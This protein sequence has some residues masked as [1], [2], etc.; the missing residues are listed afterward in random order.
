[1]KPEPITEASFQW[2]EGPI[3]ANDALYFVDIEGQRVLRL[4]PKTEELQDW[5]VGERVGCVVPRASGGLVIAGDFGF[6]FLDTD[7]GRKTPIADPEPEKKPDNRFND[8]KC[9]PAGRFWAGTI[10][11]VKK[12]GD[13]ALYVLDTDLSVSEKLPSLTNSNGI[14]W[15][16]DETLM[17]HIDTPTK[18]ICVYDYDKTTGAISNGRVAVDTSGIEGS[19]DGMAIDDQGGLWVAFCRGGT[20][21][22]LDPDSGAST[23]RIDFPMSG[24]TAC[25][26]GGP[27]LKTLYVTTGKFPNQE[28]PMNG[29]LFA[30]DA[31]ARGL[32]SFAFKG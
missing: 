31:G 7:S 17:Y 12:K 4:D 5:P 8:G 25:A 20:V 3:W 27:D 22:R 28:E 23:E 15:S 21:H 30:V 10:S 18:S 26:F 13:A 24:V 6:S 32:S 11:T 14:V 2:G 29:R 19:P 16:L 1:M 9:D